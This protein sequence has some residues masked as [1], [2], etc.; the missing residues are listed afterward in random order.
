MF[1]VWFDLAVCYCFIIMVGYFGCWCWLVCFSLLFTFNVTFYDFELW[2]GLDCVYKFV[3]FLFGCFGLLWSVFGW[4]CGF[5]LWVF[6]WIRCYLFADVGLILLFEFMLFLLFFDCLTFGFRFMLGG[7]TGGLLIWLLGCF[8]LCLLVG[9]IAL[10]WRI[11]IS[12]WINVCCYLVLFFV[13]L[14]DCITLL[15]CN[16]GEMINSR[17]AL[18]CLYLVMYY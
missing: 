14:C 1:G 3:G 10:W 11:A 2:A 4:G 15:I 7:L 17:V 16:F 9:L 13:V 6:V 18:Y 12:Y 5:D 8:M